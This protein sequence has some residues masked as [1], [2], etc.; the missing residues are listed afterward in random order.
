MPD[1]V[2][3][4]TDATFD[5]EVLQADGPVLVDF[6]AEWCGPCAKMAPVLDEIAAGR[7]AGLSV[8]KL[9]IDQN[10]EAVRNYQIMSIP[11]L[12]VFDGGQVVKRLVGARSRTT[13]LNELS[14]IREA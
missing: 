9:N 5:A 8:A 1:A 14:D 7:L 10:P 6:W 13:L 3:T 12:L 4:V 11:A 2:A